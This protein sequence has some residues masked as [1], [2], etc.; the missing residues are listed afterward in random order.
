MS[1]TFNGIGSGLDIDSIV[2]AIVD[3]ERAPAESRLNRLESSTTEELSAVGQLNSALSTFLDAVEALGDEELYQGRSVSIGDR[4][5]LG[6]TASETAQTGNYQVQIEQVATA[7]KIASQGI[8]NSQDPLGTG[9]ITIHL[10]AGSFSL[11]ID[12]ENNSL[13]DIR[14]AIN[15]SENNLGVKASIINDDTGA[16]LVLTSTLTGFDNVVAVTV[17][18]DD[19]NSRDSSGLSQLVYDPN[20]VGG[21]GDGGVTNNGK[22]LA[23][24]S[25]AIV[26]VDGLQVTSASNTIDSAI[27]GVSLNLLAA[28][29]ST[30]FTNGNTINLSVSN[31]TGA[32][33]DSINN[34]IDVYNNF[35]GIID[36]LT[37]VV[38]NDGSTGNVTGALTG[39]ATVR[40][41]VSTIRDRLQ[42]GVSDNP[43]G[44]QYLVNLGITTDEDGLLTLDEDKLTTA[45]Q[46]NF[47]SISNLFVGDKGLS[48][49]LGSALSGYTGTGGVL[50]LRQESLQRT[51]N[52]V[53]DQRERLDKRM[54]LTEARIYAQYQAADALIGSL[55]NTL[56]YLTSALSSGS[57]SK[58]K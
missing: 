42:I 53:D 22:E 55:N 37:V 44:L 54:E 58:D 40:S 29:D 3:A 14:D 34:F 46:D 1:I 47:N 6:A 52:G 10:G 33:K 43:E 13:V 2:Q 11:N 41:L 49:R 35:M 56:S 48:E 4:D 23:A 36:Q 27:E 25:D 5:L 18:D 12:S 24:A 26:Y 19:G 38:V 9:T 45:M 32:V 15:E 8:A 17:L 28:Q 30:D 57:S 39:D 51:L 16:R 7:H 50:Q 20:D 21:V 31:D